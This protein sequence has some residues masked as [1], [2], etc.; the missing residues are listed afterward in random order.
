MHRRESTTVGTIHSVLIINLV[1]VHERRSWVSGGVARERKRWHKFS[2]W[3]AMMK[4]NLNL[5]KFELSI[6]TT[7]MYNPAHG[8]WQLSSVCQSRQVKCLFLA[9]RNGNE[10][11]WEDVATRAQMV[12]RS[13]DSADFHSRCFEN[14][15]A[16]TTKCQMQSERSK[17][18]VSQ[19]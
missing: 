8:L 14:S 12:P 9:L 11:F 18:R 16:Y 10:R 6:L 7:H 17:L 2:W 4:I 1:S 13:E 15:R 5:E 19:R 3:I